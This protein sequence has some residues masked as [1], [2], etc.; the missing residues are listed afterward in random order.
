VVDAK[1]FGAY[2]T[3]TITNETVNGPGALTQP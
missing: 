1:G 3:L 2:G